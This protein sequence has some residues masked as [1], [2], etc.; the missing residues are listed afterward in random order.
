VIVSASTECFHPNERPAR[1]ADAVRAN[2][3]TV[4]VA[5][6]GTAPIFGAFQLV[7]NEGFGVARFSS[8]SFSY[9]RSVAAP[10][11]DESSSLL[12]DIQQSGTSIMHQC[13]RETCLAPGQAVLY[14]PGRPLENHFTDQRISTVTILKVPKDRVREEVGA[15]DPYLCQPLPARTALARTLQDEI[16]SALKTPSADGTQTVSNYAMPLLRLLLR[17]E[18]GLTR[19]QLFPLVERYLRAH[20]LDQPV[21]PTRLASIFRVSERTVFRIFSERGTTLERS[22]ILLRC[23]RLAGHLRDATQSGATIASLAAACGFSDAA[24]ASRCFRACF[25]V[26]PSEFRHAGLP[27]AG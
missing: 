24:H 26:T 7:A 20:G 15:V 1:W 23:Q 14:N 12:L 5:P 2:F 11:E 27:V 19:Q 8:R 4:D 3:A 25:G 18:S 9:R 13:E 22:I 17:D 6:A 10:D 16:A 21:S